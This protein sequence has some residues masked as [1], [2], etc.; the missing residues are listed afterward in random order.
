MKKPLLQKRLSKSHLWSLYHEMEA[1]YMEIVIKT[2]DL[3]HALESLAAA[4]SMS[5]SQAQPLQ[6]V[7]PQ[8][9]DEDP[10]PVQAVTPTQAAP[11]QSLPTAAP[12]AEQQAQS[13]PPTAQPQPQPLP[14]T[15]KQYSLDD[16]ARAAGQLMDSGKQNELINLLNNQFKVQSLNVLPVVQYGSFAT[17]LRGLGAQL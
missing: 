17:A 16:L 7:S 4:I 9:P 10:K 14:T 2:P 6:A 15:T 8:H 1:L 11:V 13:Q 12:Q 5:H 3:S